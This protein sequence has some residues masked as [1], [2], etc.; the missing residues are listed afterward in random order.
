MSLTVSACAYMTRDHM[1]PLNDHHKLESPIDELRAEF[2]S[3]AGQKL[4]TEAQGSA[5][6]S[7]DA[8]RKR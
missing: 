7:L 3:A 1:I 4:F 2:A 6:A 5:G 8:S